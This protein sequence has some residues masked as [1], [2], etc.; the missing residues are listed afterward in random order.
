MTQKSAEGVWMQTMALIMIPKT[1]MLA[2]LTIMKLATMTLTYLT[3]M[4]LA[5]TKTMRITTMTPT[6]EAFVCVCFEWCLF[7]CWISRLYTSLFVHCF[8]LIASVAFSLLLLLLIV[9]SYWLLLIDDGWL[10]VVDCYWLL[11]IVDCCLLIVIDCC[12]LFRAGC[13]KFMT[14]KNLYTATKASSWS[15]LLVVDGCCCWRFL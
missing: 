14:F 12:V 8:V 4:T 11:S 10:L 1:L 7:A 2:C 5:T 6:K 13:S 15:L 9:D 3:A